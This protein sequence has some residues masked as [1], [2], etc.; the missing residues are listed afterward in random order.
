MLFYAVWMPDTRLM[1]CMRRLIRKNKY[2]E[3]RSKAGSGLPASK[4]SGCTVRR[5]QA[6]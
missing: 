5:I 6:L 4:M 3:E 2:C 1:A